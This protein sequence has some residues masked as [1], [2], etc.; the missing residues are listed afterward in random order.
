MTLAQAWCRWN[1][2]RGTEKQYLRVMRQLTAAQLE[3]ML[4]E[5]GVPVVD[6]AIVPVPDQPAGPVV[7][8]ALERQP[9]RQ[10][11]VANPAQAAKWYGANCP[12]W[13]KGGAQ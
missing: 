4:T 6:V 11:D 5:R 8:V 7:D 12:S 9:V 1:G 13:R 3:R 2:Q 10:P